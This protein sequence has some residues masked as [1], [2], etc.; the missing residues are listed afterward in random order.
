MGGNRGDGEHIR[1]GGKT[2]DMKP[3]VYLPAAQTKLYPVRLADLA[4]RAGGDPRRLLN[5]IQD[6]IWALDKDQPITNVR[7]LEEIVSA[8]VPLRRFQTM[9]LAVFAGVA[10]GLAVIGIFGV[11]SFAVSQRT[12]EL[13]IRMALARHAKGGASPFRRLSAATQTHRLSADGI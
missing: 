2:D 9:L 11:L 3:Q 13:G 10:A 12:S 4:V 6:Q 8:S 5:A 1:R 7:T